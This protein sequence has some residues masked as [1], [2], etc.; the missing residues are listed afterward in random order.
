MN[1]LHPVASLLITLIEGGWL[2]DP[3]IRMAVGRLIELRHRRLYHGSAEQGRNRSLQ[4]LEQ[5]AK[6][7]AIALESEKANEQHYEV[8]AAFFELVLGPHRKYSCCFFS[9]EH[10]SLHQ[11]EAEALAMTCHRAG[12][13]NG[14]SILELG[15]G[16]GSLTLWMAEHYPDSPIVAVSNSHSQRRWIL[17][18]ARHRK[19]DRHLTV[20]TCD[21]NDLQLHQKFHRVVSVEMFEHVRNHGKLL[22]RIAGWLGEEGKLFVHIFCH[23]QFAYPFETQ[24]A[25]N[26][27]GR[28]FFSGGMMPSRD[29]F[30]RHDKDLKV[31]KQWTWNGQHYERTANAWVSNLNRNR[32]AILSLFRE[33]YGQGQELKWLMRWKVFFLACAEL[34]G[35]RHGTQWGVEHYLLEPV[36]KTVW[37]PTVSVNSKPEMF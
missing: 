16:W 20:L 19:I 35:Y 32:G 15:C 26:W 36:K 3:L 23:K 7:E 17:E 28:H 2:P 25:A 27:M 13:R 6:E 4:F 30:D 8:P 18:Q 29:L 22:E 10:S 5:A 33:V 24:G 31:V 1:L 14:I 37:E 9:N 12:L 21:I 34:F 11:A